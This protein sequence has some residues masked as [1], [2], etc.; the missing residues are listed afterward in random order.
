MNRAERQQLGAV[1]NEVR[2]WLHTAR[3]VRHLAGHLPISSPDD[4][5]AGLPLLV[6]LSQVEA[7]GDVTAAAQLAKTVW[8]GGRKKLQPA[9]EAAGRLSTF[10]SQVKAAQSDDGLNTFR[11]R[12]A[13]MSAKERERLEAVLTELSDLRS[14]AADTLADVAHMPVTRSGVLSADEDT[15]MQSMI[16]LVD[17]HA[18][19]AHGLLGQAS[20]ATGTC[21]QSHSSARLLVDLEREAGASRTAKAIRSARARS[22]RRTDHCRRRR[23]QHPVC[24]G[25]RDLRTTVEAHDRGPGHRPRT[26]YGSDEHGAGPPPAYGKQRGRA[27]PG[28]PGGQEAALR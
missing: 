19:W 22:A 27:H 4:P 10:H 3:E 20:C 16:Q 9:H 28:D 15:A 6:P 21:E 18:S 11:D 1:I 25:G 17:L 7:S 13:R 12:L 2:A 26:P 24:I 23:P 5:S 8:F 14:A